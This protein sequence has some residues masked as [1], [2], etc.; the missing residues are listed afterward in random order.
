M[1][2][3]L[4]IA[5]LVL[6][7]LVAEPLPG[8]RGHRRLL[9]WLYWSTDSLLPMQLHVLIDRRAAFVHAPVPSNQ[10]SSARERA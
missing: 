9:A 1:L 8:G 4:A 6:Y 7:L 5:A 3:T 2:A 10:R